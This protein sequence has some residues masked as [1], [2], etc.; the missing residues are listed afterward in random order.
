MFVVHDRKVLL[1]NHKKL[2]GWFPPGGHVE[3]A[4]PGAEDPIEAMYRELKE[5]TGLK[6]EDVALS[7]VGSR[8]YGPPLG[9]EALARCHNTRHLPQPWFVD[10]HDFPPVPGH[11]H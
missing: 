4:G 2:D 3:H 1:C 11:Q 6:R 5:E 10:L 8:R 9:A 7:D